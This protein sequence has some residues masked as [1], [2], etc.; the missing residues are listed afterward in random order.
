MFLPYKNLYKISGSGFPAEDKNHFSI[1][2]MHVLGGG[3]I[4]QALIYTIYK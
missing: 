3:H 4:S 2:R 1:S